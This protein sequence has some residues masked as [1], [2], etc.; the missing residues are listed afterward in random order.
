[1]RIEGSTVIAR[2]VEDVFDFVADERNEP[3]YNPRMVR[4]AKVT[5]GPIGAGTQWQATL[6]A[7]GR[8]IDL[9]IEFTR[10]DR[11]RRLGSTS[12]TSTGEITG[13][14]FFDP[15]P[16]GT[17]LVWSW[18]LHP[19]GLLRVL[20]PVLGRVGRRQEAQTWAGLK[21]RLEG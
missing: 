8:P 7:G 20:A 17:R 14:L 11:P 9:A 6:D 3:T 12:R 4:A 1:M 2:P 19:K 21:R 15:D 13:E 18:Q 5:P 10:Y 16:G